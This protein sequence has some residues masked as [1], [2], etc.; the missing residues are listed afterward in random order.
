MSE[1]NKNIL[2]KF[3]ISETLY[4][5]FFNECKRKGIKP[6]DRMRMLIFNDIKKDID[7]NKTIINPS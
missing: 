2:I 4:K 5:N 3:V 6:N 7:D 1:N